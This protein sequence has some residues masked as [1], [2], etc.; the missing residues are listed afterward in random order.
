MVSFCL[1][2][3][4]Y[5]VV[6]SLSRNA[7]FLCAQSAFEFTA[8]NYRGILA[9]RSLHFLDY[10]VNSLVV[11]AF[12]AVI[13]VFIASMAAYALTRMAFPGKTIVLLFILAVS[14][15]PQISIVGYLYRFMEGLG[16]IN[17]YR[18][19]IL[20]YVA[21][22]LPLTLWIMVSYFAQIPK[23]LD[24]AALVDGCSRWQALWKV[25]LPV[26]APGLVCAGL[27]AFIFAFNEFMFA[28]ILTVDYR[29]RTIPVGIALFQGLH[30]ELPWGTIMAASAFAVVPMV[31]LA[32]LF[33]GRIVQ[34]LTRGALKG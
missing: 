29:S 18:G 19:L 6:I 28:A 13:T 1:A 2:P 27:L 4:A 3:F 9:T 11:C 34:G 12:S 30:G 24:S 22:T 23:E 32:L 7:D 5:M 8:D 10:L 33:Q 15:F 17:T 21:W 26:A 25:T 20:P 16:W 14:M 31:L